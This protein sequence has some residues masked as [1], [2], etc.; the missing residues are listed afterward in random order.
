MVN[1]QNS[2]IYKI[3]NYNTGATYYGSTTTSL[4]RRMTSHRGKAK[5]GLCKTHIALGD[6]EHCKM[7][8]IK[9]YP[10]ETVEEL[11]SCEA[12]YIINNECVNKNTPRGLTKN[13][14]KSLT[15]KNTPKGLTNNYPRQRKEYMKS[16]RDKHKTVCECG[17]KL[18]YGTY[19][20]KKHNQS[21]KHLKFI[22]SV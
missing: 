7:V 4:S 11:E 15:N 9:S 19:A 8:L 3:V 1:Y 13:I 5:I 18:S 16:L 12:E 22:E 10:C 6:F 17:G 2:K 21:L 20:I 14:P